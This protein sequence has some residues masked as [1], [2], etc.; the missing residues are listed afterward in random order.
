MR[1]TLTKHST[2]AG[3]SVALCVLRGI[4]WTAA[5]QVAIARDGWGEGAAFKV[6]L[7]PVWAL[8]AVMPCMNMAP[9]GSP[10]MCE[11]TPV[12]LLVYVIGLAAT[13]AFY[14]FLTY[15]ALRTIYSYTSASAQKG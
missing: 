9:P 14:A 12:D 2:D 10:E 8:F 6:L 5:V 7:W 4:V 15:G 1:T 13:A 3:P 11:G